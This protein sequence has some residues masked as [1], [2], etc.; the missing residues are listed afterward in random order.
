MKQL[1]KGGTMK[2]QCVACKKIFEGDTE[3]EVVELWSKHNDSKHQ[4]LL[5]GTTCCCVLTLDEEKFV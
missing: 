2:G 3:D 4:R 1:S 5:H